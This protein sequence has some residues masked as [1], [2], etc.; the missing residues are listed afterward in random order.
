[1]DKPTGISTAETKHFEPLLDAAVTS[2]VADLPLAPSEAAR[3]AALGLVLPAALKSATQKRRDE[4]LAGRVC[5]ALA[6]ERAGANPAALVVDRLTDGSP[7]WPAGWIGTICHAAGFAAAAVARA[8][9]LSGLGIDAEPLVPFERALETQPTI[10][11]EQEWSG[12]MQSSNLGGSELFTVVFSAKESIYKC[13][14]PLTGKYFGFYDVAIHDIESD[15]GRIVAHV[16]TDLG[17]GF[18]PGRI[19]EGRYRTAN[20]HCYTAFELKLK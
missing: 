19:L 4:F 3:L 12:L 9:A 16:T 18:K 10:T 11:T 7:V 13:L 14:R 8:S 2:H 5:A 15:A 6:L 20:G 17:G 1:V